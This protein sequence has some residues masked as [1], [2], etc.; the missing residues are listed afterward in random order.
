MKKKLFLPALLAPIVVFS[1][2][3]I[4]TSSSG[5]SLDITAK[6]ATGTSSTTEGLLVPRVSRERAQ[7][8][9][10]IAIS[11]MIYVDN[12]GTGTQ[13]G[14]A[15]NIDTVG[16][17]YFDET[18]V[19]TK[20]NGA[21]STGADTSIYSN[22]GILTGNR[23]VLQQDK[24][25]AFTSNATSGANHFSIIK[26]PSNTPILSLNAVNDRIGIGGATVPQKNLHVFGT[27][28]LTNELNV[29]GDAATAGNPGT[30]GQILTSGGPGASASWANPAKVIFVGRLSASSTYT[31]YYQVSGMV[32]TT[33]DN[34]YINYGFSTLTIL[35]SGFYQIIAT[36][37]Y[38]L[39][40]GNAGTSSSTIQKN[41]GSGDVVLGIAVSNHL[42]GDTSVYH[43][44]LGGGYL[45]AGDTVSVVT[46]D[47][48]QYITSSNYTSVGIAYLG[49]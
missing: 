43:T 15:A 16:Y 29:G 47:T 49:Q 3:G 31:A 14:T 23:T 21:N 44:I 41:F 38:K 22:D 13:A 36:T 20:L 18:N 4:Q 5:A 26:Q 45:V 48:Q 25:L 34:A 42:A 40:N 10:G 8:M 39:L 32:A 6:N 28:Q 30:A 7:S 9:T 27:A 19:W 33:Y 2:V 37:N 46:N 11:T 17:Y 35:K 24:T 1:Q 12:I